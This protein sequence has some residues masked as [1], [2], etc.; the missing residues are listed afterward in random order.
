MNSSPRQDD[1]TQIILAEKQFLEGTAV[2]SH[3]RTGSL[4]GNTAL[5]ESIIAPVNK[6]RFA[7]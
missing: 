6:E 4:P 1:R 2:P 7:T 5:P 3:Q